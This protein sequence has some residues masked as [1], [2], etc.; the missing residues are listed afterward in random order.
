[1]IE[2]PLDTARNITD[3]DLYRRFR[4]ALLALTCASRRSTDKVGYSRAAIV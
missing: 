2:F 4:V 3:C 1:V